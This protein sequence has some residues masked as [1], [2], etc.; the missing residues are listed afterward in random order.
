MQSQFNPS[1]LGDQLPDT[2]PPT[3]LAAP[4]VSVS[5]PIAQEAAMPTTE[6]PLVVQ[7]DAEQPVTD[8]DYR[9]ALIS[10]LG[11]EGQRRLYQSRVL[12]VGAGGLGSPVLMYL[13][14]ASVGHLA[15]CDFDVVEASNLQRQFLHPWSRLGQPKAQSAIQTLRDFNPQVE[16]RE[17][18]RF[19]RVDDDFF[20]PEEWLELLRSYDLVIDASDNFETKYS[21]SR[22]CQVAQVPHLWGTIVG[23]DFQ[24]SLFTPRQGDGL[25][26]LYPHVPQPGTTPSGATDGVL[27]AACGQAGSVMA[28]E[29]IKYLCGL[30]PTLEG[31]V[32]FGSALFNTWRL[33]PFGG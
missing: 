29:A 6:I 24:V 1:P 28:A 23:W 10:Q 18:G 27:G 32:L 19:P 8:R 5:S 31:Q 4:E 14:A 33:V 16:Y 2:D 12:V 20:V 21:I 30:S 11:Q 3:P 17:L 25:R 15:V 9:T 22:A 26:A 13:A 7:G